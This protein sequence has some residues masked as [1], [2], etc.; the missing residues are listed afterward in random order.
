MHIGHLVAALFLAFTSVLAEIA[1][2]DLIVPLGIT[3]LSLV[4]I[5]FFLGLF[6]RKSYKLMRKLHMLAAFAALAC[7]AFHASIVLFL[8]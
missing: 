7:G 2:A 5:T 3:T 8:T 6:M 4:V 1:W